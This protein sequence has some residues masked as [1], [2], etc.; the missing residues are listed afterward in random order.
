MTNLTKLGAAGFAIITTGLLADPA[1][2]DIVHADDV[3]INGGTA[4]LCV[5]FDC[6]DGEASGSDVIRL[7]DQAL[8]LH[9]QD[10]SNPAV[11]PSNDWRIIINEFAGLGGAEYFAIEDSTANRRVFRVDA[12][13]PANAIRVLS[14]GNVGLGTATPAANLHIRDGSFPGII[15]D[16]DGSGGASFPAQKWN[17]RGDHNGF[18]IID[19]TAGIA[20]FSIVPG[21]PN[22]TLGVAASG[23]VG[24]GTGSSSDAPLEVVATPTTIGFG[25]AVIK[26]ANPAGPVAFQ[27]NP[28]DD[29]TF[30]NFAAVASNNQFNISRSGTGNTEMSLTSA[31]N[32][33]IFGTLTT[34]GPTC[35]GGCDRVFDD[36]YDLPSIAD[37]AEQMWKNRYLPA[38]GPTL[39]GQPVNLS[40]QYGNMLNE[41][42]KAHIY[43]AQLNERNQALQD[44]LSAQQEQ[45][46]VQREQFSALEAVVAGLIETAQ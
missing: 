2:A 29:A 13:A 10:T 7:K 14:D 9:F 24:I 1:S 46:S 5:G 35:G 41:L 28:N 17:I 8:R 40:E 20:P 36:D 4:N 39:Q 16:Q 44:R 43:I 42:E 6:A 23:R 30:W 38:I 3:I 45:F 37:H 12:G 25:N 31:G 18:T 34:G 22:G 21:A 26:L 33:T 27:L 11:G 15:L 19:E 32:M